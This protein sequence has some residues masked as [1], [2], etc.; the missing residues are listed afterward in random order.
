MEAVI[1]DWPYYASVS[2]M[3]LIMNGVFEKFPS[4]QVVIQESGVNWIPMLI[5]R[6]DEFYQM[7]P[8]EFMMTERFYEMGRETFEKMP[9]EH[10]LEHF[11]L[12]TQPVAPGPVSTIDSWLKV[13]HADE[14]LMFST[15]FPHNSLDTAN[16]LLEYSLDEDLQESLLSGNALEVFE[17]VDV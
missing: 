7:Y 3:N 5:N 10:F 2:A 14:M 15:D 4:L 13:V 17:H 8:D 16:W 11:H 9:S 12:S 6:S 1:N